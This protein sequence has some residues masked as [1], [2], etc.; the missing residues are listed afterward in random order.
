MSN[1]ETIKTTLNELNKLISSNSIIGDPIETEDKIL[2]P[3]VKMG[4]GF[5]TGG[6]KDLEATGAG[7]GVEPISMVVVSKGL[8]GTEGIRVLDIKKED[9]LNKSLS[10]LSLII[11]DLISNFIGPNGEYTEGEWQY[12]Q[13][14]ENN[15]EDESTSNI[16]DAE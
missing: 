14:E 2:I 7:G 13:S 5:G 15:S 9:S 8:E 10:N 1:E 12:S 16:Y 4:F 11:T 3:V 6:A